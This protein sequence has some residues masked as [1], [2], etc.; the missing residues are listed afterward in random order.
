MRRLRGVELAAEVARRLR[1][2]GFYAARH[3]T[4]ILVMVEG[5]V[6]A[7]VHVYGGDCVLRPYRPYLEVNATHLERLGAVLG[8]L[9]ERVVSG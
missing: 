4:S 6:L 1:G 2:L 9:C 3:S 5:R 8:D 7:S